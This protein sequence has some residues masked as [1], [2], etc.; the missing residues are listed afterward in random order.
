MI[1][2]NSN[3]HQALKE[4]SATTCIVG[5]TESHRREVQQALACPKPSSGKS[6]RRYPVLDTFVPPPLGELL[7]HELPPPVLLLL[8]EPP[9]RAPAS[10]KSIHALKLGYSEVGIGCSHLFSG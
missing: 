5:K 10:P 4:R 8:L 2:V 6:I 7:F 3:N 1:W 9:E